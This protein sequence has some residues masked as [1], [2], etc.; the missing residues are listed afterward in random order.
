MTWLEETAKEH[1][2]FPCKGQTLEGKWEWSLDFV[3]VLRWKADFLSCY[4]SSA[5]G[6]RAVGDTSKVQISDHL[7][8]G[9]HT[10]LQ[11][12]ITWETLTSPMAQAAP[13]TN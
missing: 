3:K 7:R 9:P 12:R 5:G 2:Y 1:W 13:Q 10:L 11:I 8:S 6:V 4:V